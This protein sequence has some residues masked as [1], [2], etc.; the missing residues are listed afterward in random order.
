VNP[1]AAV[2]ARETDIRAA[3]AKLTQISMGSVCQA[4]G[5]FHDSQRT[6]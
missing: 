1:L 3:A 6:R 4:F 5:V 2:A